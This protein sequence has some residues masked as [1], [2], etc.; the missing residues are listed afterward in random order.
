MCVAAPVIAGPGQLL[1]RALVGHVN[2]RQRIFI[3]AKTNLSS[4]VL[5]IWPTID[6]ALGFMSVTIRVHATGKRRRCGI[7]NVYNMKT[8][9]AIKTSG[10]SV[11]ANDS[12]CAGFAAGYVGK[13]CFVINIDCVRT[14]DAV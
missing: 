7:A 6:Q 8:A 2:D 13:S 3:R 5:D 9:T 1:R 11:D 14:G 10:T 12:V 4:S